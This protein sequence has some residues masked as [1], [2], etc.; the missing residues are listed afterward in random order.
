MTVLGCPAFAQTPP[1]S[2]STQFD[3]F[4]QTEFFDLNGI[5]LNGQTLSVDFRFDQPLES[6]GAV[7]AELVLQTGPHS[8]DGDYPYDHYMVFQPGTT[9]HLLG[10]LGQKLEVPMSDWNGEITESPAPTFGVLTTPRGLAG[11]DLLAYPSFREWIGGFHYDIVLPNT[12]ETIYLGRIGLKIETLYRRTPQ[13]IVETVPPEPLPD[14][15]PPTVSTPP[16]PP[17]VS[18]PPAT[19]PVTGFAISDLGAASFTTGRNGP[20]AVGYGRIKPDPGSISPSGMLILGSR[21][22]G[23]L[24]GETIV[25]DSPLLTS[26]R[27]YVELTPDG[28]VT[29]G[30]AV[31]NPNAEDATINFEVRNE[32]GAV[33]RT[34]SFTLRGAGFACDPGTDCNQLSRWLYDAPYFAGSDVQ[35]TLTFTSSAP[36]SVFGIRWTSTGAGDHLI[37]PVPVVDLSV[38]PSGGPLSVPLFAVGDGRRSEL[39]LVNPTATTIAGTVLFLDPDGVP[40]F[41]G[42]GSEYSWSADYY[43]PPNGSQKL[44]IMDVF[45]GFGFGSVRIIPGG[46]GP[47]PTAFVVY[48]HVQNGIMDFE[49]GVPVTMG[50]AFRVPAKQSPGQ[51]F[52]SLAIANPSNVEG[53]VWISLTSYDGSFILGRSRYLPAAGLILESLDSLFP[54]FAS[55]EIEGVLRVA[56]D[57]PAISVAGFR[58]R[59]NELGQLLYTT[60]PAAVENN[61]PVSEERFFPYLLNGGGF[62][63]DIVLFSGTPGQSSGTLRFIGPDGTPLDLELRVVR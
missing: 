56:T 33:Y 60:V 39:V 4:L 13:P 12:G 48:N 55:Q 1:V 18:N 37:T 15:L 58:A 57:R 31:A 50:T 32:Q 24:T 10:S 51:I 19:G 28:R 16:E 29:T 2:L 17:V 36:V 21:L 53:T 11:G 41:V 8:P 49:V 22:N 20:I 3:G 5:V 46:D 63:T 40:V 30:I 43:I 44:V 6:I 34:G 35:G 25:P 38:G 27:I 59:Y 9:A 26:G 61:L 62:T 45:G 52:T 47:A 7:W 14:P 23:V 54:E 42:F